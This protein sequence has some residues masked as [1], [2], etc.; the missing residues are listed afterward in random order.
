[1]NKMLKLIFEL[2]VFHVLCLSD[3]NKLDTFRGNPCGF[4][5]LFISIRNLF[6]WFLSQFTHDQCL[7]M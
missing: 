5:H 2:F 7:G 6:S 1:M 4:F 3:L